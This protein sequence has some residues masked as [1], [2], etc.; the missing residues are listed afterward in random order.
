MNVKTSQLKNIEIIFFVF[1]TIL[2]YFDANA[3][4]SLV[5]NNAIETS[6]KYIS[7]VSEIVLIKQSN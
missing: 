6:G 1:T 7:V 5:Y 4:V 2:P 3:R